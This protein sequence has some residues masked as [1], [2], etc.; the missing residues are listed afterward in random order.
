MSR[1][2]KD[3]LDVMDDAATE[4]RFETDRRERA[5]KRARDEADRL[6]AYADDQWAEV[7]RTAPRR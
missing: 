7:I 1:T 2:Y 4:A 3:R 6:V 5:L